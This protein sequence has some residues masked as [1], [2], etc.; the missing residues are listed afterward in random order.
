MKVSV[1]ILCWNN[2]DVL[3]M[4][5]PMLLEELKYIDHEIIFVD[6]GSTD[7]S[8][9]FMLKW[10][11]KHPWLLTNLMFNSENMGISKGKNQG[12]D[13][14]RGEYIFMMDGD[15][16][17]VPHSILKLIK[18]LDENKDKH[19]IGMYPNKWTDQDGK[20]GAT[21][22]ETRCEQLFEPVVHKCACLFYGMYRRSIF[23]DGLRLCED[24]AFGEEGYGWEDHD[25]FKRMQK[26]GVIQ[27]VAHINHPKGRYYHKINSS[28]RSMGDKV[29]RKSLS[30]RS[31]QFKEIWGA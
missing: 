1:N 18:F 17:P 13:H 8:K 11:E 24:G 7:G 23:K 26:E 2:L 6:N 27:Y 19:A 3:E 16:C 21:Y 31:K 29:F 10:K 22:F 25:F 15:V 30:D 14:S 5:L 9:E 20:S 28:I 12:I 4:S